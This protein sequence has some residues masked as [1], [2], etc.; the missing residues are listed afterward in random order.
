MLMNKDLKKSFIEDNHFCHRNDN[1]C[2][3]CMYYSEKVGKNC[4]YLTRFFVD[5]V[6]IPI[7]NEYKCGCDKYKYWREK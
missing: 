4:H 2:N 1:T 6:F 7:D 3:S 5:G